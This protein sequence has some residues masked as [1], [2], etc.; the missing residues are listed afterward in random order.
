MSKGRETKREYVGKCPFCNIKGTHTN[1]EGVLEIKVEVPL[2]ERDRINAS[3]T[4]TE[5]KYQ[6]ALGRIGEDCIMPKLYALAEHASHV[7]ETGD[8]ASMTFG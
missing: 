3:D 6:C 1:T 5:K 4:R 8:R 7:G 2:S